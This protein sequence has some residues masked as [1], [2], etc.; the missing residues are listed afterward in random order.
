MIK[1]TA[2]LLLFLISLDAFAASFGESMSNAATSGKT[3]TVRLKSDGSIAT[4][5]TQTIDVTTANTAIK[6]DDSTDN[7]TALQAVFDANPNATMY[8]PAGVYRSSCPLILTNSSGKAFNGNIL[9]AVG[10]KIKFTTPGNATDSNANMQNGILAYPKT[11]GAGGDTSGWGDG[12]RMIFGCTIEGP[13]NGAGIHLANGISWSIVYNHTATNRYGIAAETSINSEIMHSSGF[14]S[15]NAPIGYIYSANPNIYYNTPPLNTFWNDNYTIEHY[16][17]ADGGTDGTL[18]VIEDHGSKAWTIRKISRVSAQGKSN[19]TGVQYGYLGRSVFPNIENFVTEDI[20]YSIRILSSNANEG[21]SSTNITG[22]TA[23]QPNGTWNVGSMPDGFCNGGVFENLYAHGAITAWQPDCNGI[24]EF[25]PAFSN[26]STTDLLLTEGSKTVQYDGIVRSDNA[27][28]VINNSFGGFV[29]RVGTKVDIS[30]GFGTNP[31]ISSGARTK[32]FR[33]TV[34]T[35][36]TA[37]NGVLV[38]ERASPNGGGYKCDGTN[39]T[40]NTR[41]RATITTTSTTT[42]TNIDP[43]TN[44]A[45][46][47]GVGDILDL[48]CEPV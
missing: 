28:A 33:V 24:I 44:T 8:F 43:L 4:D 3:G 11:N 6:G 5:V 21:G 22:V 7:C 2:A 16:G 14:A 47:Y 9:C 25:G 40:T 12:N 46:P 23:A 15:K 29:D 26:G 17:Y 45:T 35:G 20:N 41:L 32:G 10:S 39:R 42:I 37:T 38:L 27:S 31:S 30:S 18:A 36:G 48:S 13:T 1:R 19:G 34:G